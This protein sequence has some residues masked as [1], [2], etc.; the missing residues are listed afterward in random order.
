MKKKEV[1][2]LVALSLQEVRL[3]NFSDERKVGQPPYHEW[4]EDS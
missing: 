2:S 4:E 1:N 3:K